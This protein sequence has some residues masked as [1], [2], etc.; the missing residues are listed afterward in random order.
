MGKNDRT[1]GMRRA[2]MGAIIGAAATTLLSVCLIALPALLV[3]SGRVG[4]SAQ[5][6]MVVTAAFAASCA[7]A[8][9]ARLWTRK[10]P[11]PT[12]LGVAL[13]AILVRLIIGLASAGSVK[14]DSLDIGV[15]AAMLLA[16]ALVGAVKSRKRRSRR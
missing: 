12:C 7:G 1:D 10:A 4:E 3:A 5:G 13:A 2:A 9:I 16:A 8:L 11:L 6:P 14:P 15:S